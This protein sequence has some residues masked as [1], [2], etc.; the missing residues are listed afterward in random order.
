MP[1]EKP[2]D[3]FKIK[4]FRFWKRHE[5]YAGQMNKISHLESS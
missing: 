1:D 2:S 5:L 3:L 4:L